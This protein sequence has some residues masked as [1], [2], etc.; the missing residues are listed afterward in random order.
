M[1]QNSHHQTDIIA[2]NYI[3]VNSHLKKMNLPV[4]RSGRLYQ[5]SV[6]RM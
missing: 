2:G 5:N 6:F 3:L 4:V 1:I